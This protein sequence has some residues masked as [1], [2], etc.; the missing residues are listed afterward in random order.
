V[1][2]GRFSRKKAQG[3]KLGNPKNLAAAGSIGRQALISG[4]DVQRMR[5]GTALTL[6]YRLC[7]LHWDDA[8]DCEVLYE[9]RRTGRYYWYRLSNAWRSK[10]SR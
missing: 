5:C 6:P 2:Q 10:K 8:V 1:D 7:M 3:A 9:G 4:A